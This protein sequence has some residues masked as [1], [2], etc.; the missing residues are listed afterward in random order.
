M[1]VPGLLNG[2]EMNDQER[3]DSMA[4]RLLNKVRNHPMTFI[5]AVKRDRQMFICSSDSGTYDKTVDKALEHNVL[6]GIYNNDGLKDGWVYDDLR[7]I[8]RL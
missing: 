7:F 2:E 3:L 1:E 4:S 6:I 5:A 8:F